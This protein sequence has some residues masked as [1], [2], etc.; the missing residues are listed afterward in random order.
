MS[1]VRCIGGGTVKRECCVAQPSA[2]PGASLNGSPSP[3]REPATRLRRF[4]DGQHHSATSLGVTKAVGSGVR[5][6]ASDLLPVAGDAFSA[7]PEPAPGA[8]GFVARPVHSLPRDGAERER[9]VRLPLLLQALQVAERLLQR[10]DLAAVLGE[11]AG[12]EGRL[13]GVELRVGARD[14]RARLGAQRARAAAGRPAGAAVPPVPP[15]VPVPPD[16]VAAAGSS[17]RRR[18]ASAS[19]SVGSM[20]TTCSAL[21]WPPAGAGA[22]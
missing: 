12:L 20:A 9:N 14:E 15:P 21:P 18:R 6:A 22:R 17:G 1:S 11:V 13:G 4:A 19:P 10:L 16:V 8:S 7:H 3:G 5:T 2:P